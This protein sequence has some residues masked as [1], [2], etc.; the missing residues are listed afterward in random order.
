MMLQNLLIERQREKLLL[1]A[2]SV[3][4]TVALFESIYRFSPLPL[5]HSIEIVSCRF[6][7]QLRQNCH[8]M[9]LIC[10]P[11]GAKKIW[12]SF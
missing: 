4:R 8:L 7:I 2:L 3:H 10:S 11:M 9:L 12:R 1:C 6:A 5:E